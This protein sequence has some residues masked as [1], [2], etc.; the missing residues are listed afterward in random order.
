MQK[1]SQ[2]SSGSKL[3]VTSSVLVATTGLKAST[4]TIE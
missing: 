1:K 4:R 2:K 3:E